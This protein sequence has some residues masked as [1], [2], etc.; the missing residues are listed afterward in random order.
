MSGF[1]A[2]AGY[3]LREFRRSQL[4]HTLGQKGKGK[5]GRIE[6][7][8]T[9]LRLTASF[10]RLAASVS[11]VAS[12][13]YLFD[14]QRGDW[15][16]LLKAIVL[17]CVILAI[18]GEAIPQAWARYSG[19]K[20]LRA[21][22]GVMLVLRYA[23]YPIV[24]VMQAFD[25]PIRRLS[26]A[27]EPDTDEHIVRQEIMEAASEGRAEGIV[28]ADEVRMIESVME[29]GHRRAGEIMTPRT[30]IV[31]M[32][33]SA[34]WQDACRL[35]HTAGHTRIPLYDGDLDNIIGVVYA[36]DLL[37][38][39]G[40]DKPMELRSLMHKPF[41]VPQT[42]RLDDLL[43]EFKAR[44]VHVAIVLDEYGGTAGLVSFEDVLEE[45][46]GDISDE[47]DRPEP[48]LMK[49]L[50]DKTAEVDG[51]MYIDDLNKAMRL[52]IPQDADYDTVAGLVFS[53][54]GYIPTAGEIL[55]AHGA[56]FTVLAA[57]ERKITRMKVE[58][59]PQERSE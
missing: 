26:G 16:G 36:K 30:D 43:R 21:I 22:G 18:F 19:A 31:A 44:K 52:R 29:F 39:V 38:H 42:K 5:A 20:I 47:Y 53:E 57:D 17:A 4:E 40:S 10:C 59:R 51:R 49:R 37:E 50:D 12:L 58:L 9:A 8:L 11:L 48:A 34:T 15:Q 41:F 7:Q 3:S 2:L 35:I 24:A 28:D 6:S 1:F 46:V 54:L 14:A 13:F 45:I 27:L 25:T 56:R 23:L 33:A 55:D 32:R